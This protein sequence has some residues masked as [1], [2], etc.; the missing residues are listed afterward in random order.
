[1][2]GL[3]SGLL[4]LLLICLACACFFEFVNGFHDTAN[5]VA[6]VIYTNSLKPQVAVVWSAFCNFIGVL[7]GGTA[8]AMGIVNLLPVEVLI[9]QDIHHSIAMVLALLSSAIIWNMGTWYYGLPSSSTH[10]L[11]GSIL[12]VGFAFGIMSNTGTESVNWSKVKETGIS[13]LVSPLFGFMVAGGILLVLKHMLSKSQP[14]LFEEPIK[15]TPPPMWIRG[16]LVLTCTLVSFFH[17]SNDGQKG[18]GLVMLI[19]IGIVPAWFALNTELNIQNINA[20]VTK[21]EQRLTSL[22]NFP[23]GS[24]GYLLVGQS[25]ALCEKLKQDVAA[26]PGHGLLEESNNQRAQTL[27][28]A[29]RKDILLLNKNLTKLDKL[30]DSKITADF[31]KELKADF[32]EVKAHTDYAPSWVTLMISISLGLGTMIGWKRIVLTIGEKIGK[33]H[34]TYGQGASAELVAASTIGVSS[35]LGLPV[36]TTHVLSSGVAGTMVAADG[37]DNLQMSTV[38]NILLAWLLTFPVSMLLAGSLFYLFTYIF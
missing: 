35:F 28:F 27:N 8:V 21:I 1:M 33:S 7:A 2:F 26:H 24:E 6:T 19:L 15:D 5:A 18:V 23:S 34:L 37:K 30:D 25:I 17:G 3:E 4:L 31:K 14:K 29:L 12:G 10:T 13:L 20:P 38:K 32:K 36:S 16:V 22:P 11:V 9:D